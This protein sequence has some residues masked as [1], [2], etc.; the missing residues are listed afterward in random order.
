MPGL[1]KYCLHASNNP[2]VQWNVVPS[3]FHINVRFS[4]KIWQFLFKYWKRYKRLRRGHFPPLEKH[5]KSFSRKQTILEA[6]SWMLFSRKRGKSSFERQ[7]FY[8]IH[9]FTILFLIAK[10]W[11]FPQPRFTFWVFLFFNPACKW[12]S[13]N[14]WHWTKI[15]NKTNSVRSLPEIWH[16]AG[17]EIKHRFITRIVWIFD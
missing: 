7:L 3:I 2:G 10:Y 5:W 6:Q 17:V 4:C 12:R 14:Q 8:V 13:F 11:I 15:R 1:S 16:P 9:F